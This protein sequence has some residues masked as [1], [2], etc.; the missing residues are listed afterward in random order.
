MNLNAYMPVAGERPLD[1]IL[2]DSGFC[3]IFRTIGCIGDSLSSGEFDS[4][5]PD[6]TILGHDL[7]EHSWG[8]YLARMCG[9]Q[10]Y[11]F[12]R[13]NMTAM[14][15]CRTFAEEQGYWDPALACEA[16]I[17]ALGVNDLV[18]Y[19]H[20]PGTPADICLTD[21][22]KNVQTFTG[23]YAQIIQRLKEISPRAKFFLMTI[24]RDAKMDQDAVLLQ[25][26]VI[27]QLGAFFDNT[28]V[29]D[30][31]RY[32][33]PYDAAFRDRF[34]L[35]GHMSPCG[36]LLTAKMVASYIDFIIRNDMD[37]FKESAYCCTPYAYRQDGSAQQP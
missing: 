4:I 29:L 22:R 19:H 33:P 18:N 10:V 20:Q 27:R 16:Y 8:Q 31:Y 3:S 21:W 14:E 30:F 11:N 2:Q 25:G 34:F 23:Y 26:S 24:P 7:Y 35:G 1:M 32:A 36:Y 12:S 5:Q 37:A 6:G 13:G 17:L 9:S 28:Y 15:Y